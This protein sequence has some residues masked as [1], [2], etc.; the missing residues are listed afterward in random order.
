M[1]FLGNFRSNICDMTTDGLLKIVFK[2]IVLSLI[3]EFKYIKPSANLN[4]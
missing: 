2:L 1:A 3:L 4:L